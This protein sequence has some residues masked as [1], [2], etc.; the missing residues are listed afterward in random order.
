MLLFFALTGLVLGKADG[1]GAVKKAFSMLNGATKTL[2]CQVGDLICIAYDESPTVTGAT[3]QT[4]T[5]I[6]DVPSAAYNN[7]QQIW[8]ATATSV[9]IKASSLLI[10]FVIRGCTIG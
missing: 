10:G 7:V 3:K 2:S 4:I 6:L 5:S 8:K 1:S 9:T